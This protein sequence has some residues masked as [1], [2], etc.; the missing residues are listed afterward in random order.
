MLGIQ[1]LEELDRN[2]DEAI[3]QVYERCDI[4][5]LP[6]LCGLLMALKEVKEA[7]EGVQKKLSK[8][9]EDVSKRVIPE[10][11]EEMGV[12]KIQVPS[13]KKS[14][15]PLVKYSASMKDRSK[16]MD[17]LRERGAGSLITETVNANSLTAFLKDYQ[18]NDGV[19]P[20]QDLFTFGS[21][22]LTGSSSYTPK[23]G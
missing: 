3:K 7:F 11:F 20:P 21:Y 23:E 19:D 8:V 14:F 18:I 15:Y 2:T 13:L 17:W 10:R 1:G 9:V 5:T 4:D 6:E 16:G 12:D 22:T